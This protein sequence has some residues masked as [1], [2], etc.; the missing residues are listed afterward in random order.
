MQRTVNMASGYGLCKN[1]PRSTAMIAVPGV[2]D[3]ARLFHHMG[4]R[5][6]LGKVGHEM[7]Y[8]LLRLRIDS[9]KVDIWLLELGLQW[10]WGMSSY[11]RV[12]IEL[13]DD[14]ELK[15]NVMVAMLKINK[16]GFYTCNVRVE[17]EWKPLNLR[18]NTANSSSTKKIGVDSTNKVSDSSPF[19]VLYLVDNDVEMGT[20]VGTSNL[21]NNGAN[22]SGSSSGMQAILMD[23]ASNPL[24]KVK[25]PD[26]HNSEYE[27]DSYDNG[28]YDE[29]PYDDDM[30]KG[31][32]LSE[33]IQT[34]CDKLDI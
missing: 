11:A 9:R 2:G 6:L 18:V 16:E 25:Y 28:D 26:D 4:C 1:R 13:Q 34:I 7:G 21:D 5:W 17:Y 33:E 22:L 29:D 3:M 32:D 20:N 31:Q 30:C 27:R 23:E 19:E 14:V 10:S 15:D 8:K 24:K 12:M